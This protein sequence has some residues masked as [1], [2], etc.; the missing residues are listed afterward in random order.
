MKKSILPLLILFVFILLLT[1]LLINIHLVSRNRDDDSISFKPYRL[2]RPKL[3][4]SGTVGTGILD[5][6]EMLQMVEEAL[7]LIENERIDEAEDKIRTVLV[8]A[9]ENIKALTIL[10]RILYA[11][12]RFTEAEHIYRRQLQYSPRNPSTLNN[13]GAA[14]CRQG[15][16]DEA[17]NYVSQ[18]A[19]LS[20]DSPD[21]I[22]NLAGI[23]AL[24]G[25]R[26]NALERLAE[27]ARLLGPAI[28]PL[29]ENPSFDSI[30]NHREFKEIIRKARPQPQKTQRKT[31]FT[32]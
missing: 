8:F 15:R 30:R 23:Y 3:P 12:G 22:I 4:E 10:G 32:P 6:Q 1:I 27:A 9:P 21:I 2:A 20:P 26:D 11:R 31:T 13:L 17:I 7:L 14:L 19:T 16:F 29:S 25:N 5:P 24:N 28:L 18:A